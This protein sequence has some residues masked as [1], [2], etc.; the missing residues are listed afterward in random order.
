MRGTVP[1]PP[2]TLCSLLLD[3]QGW[4]LHPD[5]PGEAVASWEG[6]PQ[7]MALAFAATF[8]SL[9][10]CPLDSYPDRYFLLTV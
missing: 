10:G 5:T 9:L 4:S 7:G 6:W 3:T 2:G 1:S 8:P